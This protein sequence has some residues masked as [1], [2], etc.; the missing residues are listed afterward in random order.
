MNGLPAGFTSVPAG[1][2][3]ERGTFAGSSGS[4]GSSGGCSLFIFQKLL[5][6]AAAV[7]G[8]YAAAELMEVV[9]S[10]NMVECPCGACGD[11]RGCG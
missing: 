7:E 11:R 8:E 2:G 4:S 1:G 6:S 10:A 5:G 3:W 9:A